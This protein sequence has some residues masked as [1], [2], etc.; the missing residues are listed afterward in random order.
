[1]LKKI[2]DWL[3]QLVKDLWDAFTD[4][5]SDWF[6]SWLE[7]QLNL[8]T[9]MIH[10]IPSPDF[11]SQHSIGSLLGSAGPTVAWAVNV[12]QVGPSA[13]VISSAIVF[14]ILRRIFT[15]GIW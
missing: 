4:F 5:M 9:Y 11:L 7:F 12:F 15:L 3:V 10:H 2:T 13:A 8:V 14:F 1:M 6:L